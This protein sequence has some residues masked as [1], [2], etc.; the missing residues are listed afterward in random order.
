MREGV[1][2]VSMDERG[3]RCAAHDLAVGRDGL[4]VLCRRRAASPADAATPDGSPSRSRALPFVALTLAVAVLGC[5]VLLLRPTAAPLVG[6]ETPPANPATEAL[7]GR[8]PTMN[9][10]PGPPAR[11]GASGAEREVPFSIAET[12]TFAPR[13]PPF[14]DT[15]AGFGRSETAKPGP[16]PARATNGVRSE[17]ELRAA[18]RRVSVTMYSTEWC[19]VCTRARTWLRA[20]GVSFEERDVDKSESARRT[21]LALNP[22]GGV[23][24]IDIDGEVLIGFGAPHMQ[25]ALRRA[26]ERRARNF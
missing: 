17:G 21:Q 26:A 20:N 12:P 11:K 1:Y 4:C 3:G 2:T 16:A 23:P 19:P 13:A 8:G 15:D 25:G 7:V 18:M 9:A 22:K 14:D 6:A 10:P 5:V 24:T